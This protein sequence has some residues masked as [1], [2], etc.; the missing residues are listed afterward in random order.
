MFEP[1]AL[2]LAR[3]L[4]AKPDDN[5]NSAPR[6]LK[7]LFQVNYSGTMADLDQ[8]LRVLDQLLADPSLQSAA[9]QALDA[10]LK[11]GNFDIPYHLEF[12]GHSRCWGWHP[13]NE[14]A[15]RRWYAEAFA[16]LEAL[17][18]G[19][20]ADWYR[21]ALAKHFRGLW[22]LKW[23]IPDVLEALFHRL[24]AQEFW[25]EGWLATQEML[26]SQEE[27]GNDTSRLQTLADDLAPRT[28]EHH[29]LIWNH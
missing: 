20:Q 29:P 22:R 23:G 12:G 9:K 1:A 21:S 8:R 5:Q 10:M 6:V 27:K 18:V 7:L 25:T 3:F 2:S 28:L 13:P 15:I 4:A 17:T 19:E 16:R 11:A 14:E 24:S 26:R